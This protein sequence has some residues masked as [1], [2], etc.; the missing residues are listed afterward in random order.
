MGPGEQ[1]GQELGDSPNTYP[2]PAL[3]PQ[4]LKLSEFAP[5]LREIV[6]G[7][8]TT[9][10]GPGI[11]GPILVGGLVDHVDGNLG[12]SSVYLLGYLPFFF[13]KDFIY[14]FLEKGEGTET[15]TLERYIDQL[16]LTLP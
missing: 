8:L 9:P 4:V 13:L 14:L 10:S 16:P 5:L 12:A 15:S 1:S 6:P 11:I 3:F 7:S 2:F